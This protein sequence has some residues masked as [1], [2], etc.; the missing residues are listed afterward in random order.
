[1]TDM[2]SETVWFLFLLFVVVSIPV[3]ASEGDT[4]IALTLSNGEK[5]PL[6]G[7]G[8]GNLQHELINGVLESSLDEHKFHLIDTARASQNERIISNV[9]AK[10]GDRLTEPIHIVTKVWYTHLG[11]ERTKLSVKESLEDLSSSA[12]RNVSIHVHLLLHWPKCDETIPWMN[13]EEEE[14]NLPQYVKDAG[15][16]PHL[17]KDNAWKESWRALEDLY[18]DRDDQNEINMIK[19]ASIGVS[20][21]HFT[22]MNYLIENSRI[23]PHIYQGNVWA[24]LF[25]PNIM[26][27]LGEQNI[28]FQAYNVMNGMVTRGQLAPIA[29]STLK[30]IGE[31]YSI[32]KQRRLGQMTGK[33]MIVTEAM[34][35]M[36]WLLQKG[37]G[38]IPRA[39][40]S[41]HLQENS[42][43]SLMLI[44]TLSKSDKELIQ[45]AMS[46]LLRGE[47]LKV[48]ATFQNSLESGHVQIYWINGE[49]GEEAPV[50]DK[51]HPGELHT[52]QTHPGHI[53]V[54]YDETKTK[55]R[56]FSVTASYGENEIFSVDEL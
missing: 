13:C 5:L 54:A 29:F 49:S 16:P 21:F 48:E 32:R 26:T 23:K 51:I 9:I 53:F 33:S 4:P 46:A 8:V 38:I 25:E 31:S 44:P 27:L 12:P 19:I 1:M 14:N 6:V 36:A 39:S 40:S 15:P 35:I 7:I 41:D 20:N 45:K 47:D 34:V 17:D 37:I 2:G 18:L 56:Q 10:M 24:V 22:D 3:F 30:R 52:I 43:E 11:Y 42:P 50:V 28:T 55:R